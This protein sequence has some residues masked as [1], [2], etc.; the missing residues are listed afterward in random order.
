VELIVDENTNAIMANFL[1]KVVE[2][3]KNL[4]RFLWKK[5]EKFMGKI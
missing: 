3:E 1:C 4:E 2:V 5:L